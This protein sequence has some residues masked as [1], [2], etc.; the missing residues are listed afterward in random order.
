MKR[1]DFL[2]AGLAANAVARIGPAPAA[3]P[4][5]PGGSAAPELEFAEATVASLGAAFAGGRVTSHRLVEHYLERIAAIDRH[6]PT[7]RSV[8]EVNPDALTIAGRLDQERRAGKLRGPLH[9]IPVL[10]K[11]NIATADRM[12]TT[13]GSLAL[14][15]HRPP[16][17]AFIVARLREAGAVLLGKT[18]LSEWANARSPVSTSGWSGRGGQTKNPYVLDR[19][20]CG[21]SS[22]SGAAAAA[23]LTALAIGTETSGSIV[24]PSS[25]N[26]LVG[27]KPTVG[28]WSRTAIIPISA[29]QDTAGPMCRTVADAAI[30]LSA[31]RGVDPADAR[32]AESA[33]QANA[34]YVSRLAGATLKGARLGVIR[35]GLRLGP[36]TEALYAE[37]LLTLKSA[38]AEL[39]DPTNLPDLEKTAGPLEERVMNVEFKAGVEAYLATLGSGSPKTMDDLIAFNERER[40]REMPFFGQEGLLAAAGQGSVADPAYRAAVTAIVPMA[41]KAIDDLLTEHRLDALIAPTS[42]P[43]WVTDHVHGDRA[44]GGTG[45]A[46]AVAGYPHVTVPAG[47]IQGLPVGLSFMGTAWSEPRLLELAAAFERLTSARKPPRFIP[48]I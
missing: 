34:D 18:N 20:P 43:A 7:L 9:G 31:L 46:A 37:L 17:D 11:D 42:E 32:S 38:G 36:K 27:I 10:I 33:G 47:S 44:T 22:G 4:P 30:L 12:E 29:T 5:P 2:A 6:G 23:N 15:G 21:S 39:V 45:G 3:P 24:C 8:I 19:N 13:A 26:G 1:R 35:E 48:S 16:R 14:V 41:R 25:A 28:L 40:A